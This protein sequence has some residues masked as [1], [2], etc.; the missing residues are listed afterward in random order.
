MRNVNSRATYISKTT[1]NQ[2]I[3]C[4]GQEITCIILER[5]K[6]A[7]YNSILFDETTD[8]SHTSQMSLSLRY[9]HDGCVREDFLTFIDAHKI[10]YDT[11]SLEPILSGKVLGQTI[12]KQLKDFSL[13][14]A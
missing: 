4:C 2:I 6:A 11:D 14:L 3:D 12:V 8:I 9:I 10:Y 13:D 5:V 1:Q 7:K